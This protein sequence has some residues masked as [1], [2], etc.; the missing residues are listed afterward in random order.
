MVTPSK[1]V[2]GVNGKT[3]WHVNFEP[4]TS[5]LEGMFSLI[6]LKTK[7]LLYFYMT[8][9]LLLG[10]GSAIFRSEKSIRENSE[11]WKPCCKQSRYT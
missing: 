9:K 3:V 7:K 4:S 11:L 10:Q 5:S 2:I 8:S 6:K 1:F